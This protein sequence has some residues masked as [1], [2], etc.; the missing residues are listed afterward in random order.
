MLK[1]L[2]TVT[3]GVDHESAMELARKANA[4]RASMFAKAVE[5]ECED[6]PAPRPKRASARLNAEVDGLVAEFSSNSSGRTWGDV[7]AS[8]R[9]GA[10]DE[11]AADLV[12]GFDNWDRGLS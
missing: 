11:A 1:Y 3:A 5:V 9:E 7:E 10:M 4:P 8:G 12:E 6:K 2:A